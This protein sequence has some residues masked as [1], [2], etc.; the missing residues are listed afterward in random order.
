MN[1]AQVQKTLEEWCKLA[2][3]SQLEPIMAFAP[4]L[5]MRQKI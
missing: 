2:M 3:E 1:P 5:K 4:T